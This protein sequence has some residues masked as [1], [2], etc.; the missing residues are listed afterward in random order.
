ML[1]HKKVV[2][3]KEKQNWKYLTSKIESKCQQNTKSYYLK[4]LQLWFV[5]AIKEKKRE[6]NWKELKKNELN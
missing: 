2:K 1:Q 3:M 4:S 5:S 6:E